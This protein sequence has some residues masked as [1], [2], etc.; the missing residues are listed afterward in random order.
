[1]SWIGNHTQMCRVYC[2]CH[3]DL[4]AK[5]VSLMLSLKSEMILHFVIDLPY[6]LSQYNPLWDHD[7]RSNF[8]IAIEAL[9][10]KWNIIFFSVTM[11][12]HFFIV[13]DL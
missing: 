4:E 13:F 11:I 9:V 10:V 3:K 2:T 12:S 7:I 6:V 1:M 8:S 5:E